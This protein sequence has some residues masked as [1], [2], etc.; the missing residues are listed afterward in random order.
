MFKPQVPTHKSLACVSDDLP[1]LIKTVDKAGRINI[2]VPIFD[3]KVGKR[4]VLSN[5]IGLL[6]CQYTAYEAGGDAPAAAN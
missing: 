1:V 6:Y 3:T 4:L 2:I 5:D